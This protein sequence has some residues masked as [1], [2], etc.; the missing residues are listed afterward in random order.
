MSIIEFK[1]MGRLLATAEFYNDKAGLHRWTLRSMN[2]NIIAD[3]G[4]GYKV[5]A[6]ALQGLRSVQRALCCL[7][8]L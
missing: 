5:K 4:Q 6:S 2:G 7:P 1:N 3:S 8:T